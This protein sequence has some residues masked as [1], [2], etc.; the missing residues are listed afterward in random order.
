MSKRAVSASSLPA[1][2]E[3]AQAVSAVGLADARLAPLRLLEHAASIHPDPQCRALL[4]QAIERAQAGATFH[5]CFGLPSDWREREARRLLARLAVEGELSPAQVAVELIKGDK[6]LFKA[7]VAQ[8]LRLK[9]HAIGRQ[10]IWREL[11][12]AGVTFSVLR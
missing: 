2:A 5:D 8:V 7:E 9:G 1:A 11:K 12:A 4:A 6:S 10:Q 3:I